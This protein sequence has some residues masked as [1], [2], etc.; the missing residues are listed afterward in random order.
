MKQM[1]TE[2]PDVVLFQT[3]V[4]EDDRGYFY[5]SYRKSWISDVDFVQDN[6]SSSSRNTLRGIHYQLHSPQGKLVRVTKG[7]V[8]DVAVDLRRSSPT[9]QKYV[10]REL[11]STDKTMMWIPEG[12]GHAFLALTEQ[13]EFQYKCSRY[14]DPG[15][16]HVIRWDDPVLGIE[17]PIG[18]PLVS[19]QDAAGAVL[20]EAKL[21]D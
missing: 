8:L 13:V 9:F 12:F 19:E 21:F 3:H 14:Y 16:Q 18:D 15:D 1:S 17:W 4:I 6:Q 7:K 10:A 20:S 11:S 5:E 2:I